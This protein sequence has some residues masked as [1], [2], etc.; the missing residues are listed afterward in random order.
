MHSLSRYFKLELY[1][2]LKNVCKNIILYKL[3]KHFFTLNTYKNI[4][5]NNLNNLWVKLW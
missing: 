5:E 4:Y 2:L 1:I 3:F